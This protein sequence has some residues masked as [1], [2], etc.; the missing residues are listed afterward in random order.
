MKQAEN[1]TMLF[2]SGNKSQAERL[3]ENMSVW[4]VQDLGAESTIFGF[5]DGSAI[6]VS[7]PDFRAA[8]DEEI[9]GN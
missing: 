1:Y 3:A 5:A 6:F 8:T 2:E 7:G 4:K 9:R